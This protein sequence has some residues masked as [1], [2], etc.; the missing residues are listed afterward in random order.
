VRSIEEIRH[1]WDKGFWIP[2]EE[3][4][5]LMWEKKRGGKSQSSCR[6]SVGV[7]PKQIKSSCRQRPR[8]KHTS[9][10]KRGHRSR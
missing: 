3:E 2:R 7:C 5:A 9:S 4:A 6:P 1:A 10:S 8:V